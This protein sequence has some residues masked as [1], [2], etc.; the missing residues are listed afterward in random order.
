MSNNP[1]KQV[2]H[3]TTTSPVPHITFFIIN[4]TEYNSETSLQ[5]LSKERICHR[6]NE[7]Q[8][9]ISNASWNV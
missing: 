6:T 9:K 4:A 7:K 3:V 2:S 5:L 8:N 1:L